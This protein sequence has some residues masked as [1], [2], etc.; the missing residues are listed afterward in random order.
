VQVSLNEE[1]KLDPELS[2]RVVSLATFTGVVLR[3]A[4]LNAYDP[5]IAKRI[6]ELCLDKYD[7]VNLTYYYSGSIS[8]FSRNLL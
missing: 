1:L 7:E 3:P 5:E 6:V 8:T 2:N 4:D